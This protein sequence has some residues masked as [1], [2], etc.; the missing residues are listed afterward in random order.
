MKCLDLDLTGKFSIITG[1]TSGIGLEIADLF[2]KHG[3]KTV[4]IGRDV[5]KGRVAESS[6]NKN[7]GNNYC[8]FY[9]CDVGK[10]AEVKKTCKEIFSKFGRVDILV[11]NASTEFSESINEIKLENWKKV[12][13]TNVNGA[14]YFIRFLI[15]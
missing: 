5:S 15:D 10:A 3:C 13:D 2:C 7:C 8:L 4:V 1:G 14:F 9:K 6:I 11:L 12:M